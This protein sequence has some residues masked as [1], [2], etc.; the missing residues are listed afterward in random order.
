MNTQ[1]KLLSLLIMSL[2]AANAAAIDEVDTSQWVCKFCAFE[3]AGLTGTVDLGLG[4]VSDD[5]YQFGDYTGLNEKGAFL[6]GNAS[7]RLRGEDTHYWNIEAINLGLDSRSLSVEGGA[8][9]H[10]KL[11]F[12]YDELPHYISDSTVTPFL[13][14]GT[15][16]LT[17]PG[18]WVRASTTDTM[19][20]LSNSLHA[21]NLDTKRKRLGVGA[22]LISDGDWQYSVNY[23][24]ETREGTK[25]IAG[26]FFFSSAQLVM[27]VDYVTQ[28]MDVAAIYTTEKLQARLAYYGSLFSDDN[29]S[30]TWDNPY[31]AT[32][33]DTGQ[34]ALPPDNQF[35]QILGSLGYQFS[36]TT[37]VTTDIALGR[38]T[39]DD[40]YLPATTNTTLLPITLP[41]NS[42]DGRVDTL[43]AN[44]KLTSSLSQALRVAA[45]YTYNDHDNQTPQLDYTWV[46][47]D[48]STNATTRSNLPYSFTKE[49][50]KLNADYRFTPTTKASVGFDN[51][52]EKRTYQEVSKADENTFWAKASARIPANLEITAKASH[53]ERDI[54]GY[55]VLPWLTSAENP[56]LRKYNMADRT[57][58]LGGVRVDLVGRETYS[59]G[60]GIDYSS[61]DYTNSQVGLKE[62]QEKALSVDG[63]VVL[64]E[65]THIFAFANHEQIDSKQAGSAAVSYPDWTAD[66]KDVVNTLGVGLKQVLIE[67]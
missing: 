31:A 35:H 20:D 56:L 51:A 11:T 22:T 36:D 62:S 6:I 60:V 8:Q 47:T 53:A 3:E 10:Y 16:T 13:G 18:S 33:I 66:N 32:S 40:D 41:G 52:T 19:T 15:D 21:E 9:G 50:I 57:R 54:T 24:H 25:A 43:N 46:S 48:I 26:S 29:T 27:P 42:L 65:K 67:D 58:E 44:I 37:R 2:L 55:E 59:F 12:S 39:Q 7:L 45:A 49:A 61:D 38:M 1:K 64:S 30:L 34:L 63:S 14:A 5:S 4:Y 23:R 28:Q 17:L